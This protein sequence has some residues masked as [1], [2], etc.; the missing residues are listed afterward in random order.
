M[1]AEGIGASEASAAAPLSALL[2]FTLADELLFARVQAFVALAVVLPR[3]GFVAYGADERSLVG[4]CPEMR[5]QVVG[6]GESLGAEGALESSRVL[7]NALR[8]AIIRGTRRRL[9]LRVCEAENIVALVWNR[10]C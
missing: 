1:A 3:E 9:I 10:G 7:L 4:M 6:A 2:Q 8:V 5:P